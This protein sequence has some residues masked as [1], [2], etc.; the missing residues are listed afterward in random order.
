[1]TNLSQFDAGYNTKQDRIL[2]RITDKESEEYRLWLTRRMCR[3]FLTD[4]KTRT[5]SYRITGDSSVA[6][7]AD[8]QSAVLLADLEQK[9]AVANR[10]FSN[11]FRAGD[12]FPLGQE[13]MV[14]ETINLHPNSKGQGV[15]GLSLQD[16]DGRGITINVS[17]DLLN[18]IFEVIER[19]VHQADWSLDV[20]QAGESVAAVLQ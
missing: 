13:G 3:S 2:L 8:Q 5:S 12:S 20:P 1:M 9:A 10:D 18:S 17:V 16:A 15:H 19:V 7:V 4:F 14:V 6:P 11:K